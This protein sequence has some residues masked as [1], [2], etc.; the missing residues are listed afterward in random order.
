[1]SYLLG[2]LQFQLLKYDIDSL[3]IYALTEILVW[4]FRPKTTF[5]PETIK[6]FKNC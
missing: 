5:I 3:P 2:S 1:M 6:Q 4:H